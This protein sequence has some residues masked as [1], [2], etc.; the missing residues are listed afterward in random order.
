MGTSVACMLATMHYSFHEETQFLN[1]Q[2]WG[3]VPFLGPPL[4][5]YGRLIDDSIQIW[6][7]DKVPTH[8]KEN[9]VTE[10][11]SAM[12]FGL[13][14]WDVEDPAREV[15]FLDLTIK[16][17]P[18]GTIITKT[19]EKPTNLHLYIEPQSAHPKGV[20]KSLVFGSIL[21]YWK[22]NTLNSDFIA[23]SRAFF[24][25]LLNRGYE[26]RALEP[27]F[28][29]V[30]DALVMQAQRPIMIGP[31]RDTCAPTSRTEKSDERLFLHWEFHP[32]DISRQ[33]IR[34]AYHKYLEPVVSA[35]PLG[36]KQLTIAYSTPGNLRRCLTK[37][38][39]KQAPG[40]RASDFIEQLQPPLA[41]P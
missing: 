29:N 7:M 5:L 1:Y 21:R 19:Y 27:M 12:A 3:L 25:H 8:M 32:Q 16:L 18:N 34:Q 20:L 36:I 10:M 17:Q 33:A 24:Q 31:L 23:I 15:D 38:Q 9:F 39:L 28:K 4:L 26:R 22:Q 2:K 14:T 35:P 11:K 13:L 30:V 37:T 41:G 40:N 6:D